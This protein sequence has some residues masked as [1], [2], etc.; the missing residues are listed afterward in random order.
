MEKY[1]IIYADP[2]WKYAK[3]N[4]PK[5]RFGIGMHRYKGMTFQEI[6]NL[7][8]FVKSL[9]AENCALFMWHVAPKLAQ[10]PIDVIFKNWGFRYVTKA[11]CWVK[12]DKKF[13]LRYLPGHYTGSNTEDCYLGIKGKMPRLNGG[14]NQVVLAPLTKHS[15]KPVI[16]RDRIVQLYGDLPRI[17]LFA[18][19]VVDGWDSW[20]D[21]IPG[22]F[23]AEATL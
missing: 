20:G 9:A 21:A 19:K 5:T 4:N 17:E 7:Q 23:Y 2:P 1:N 15:E 16:V 18:T 22:S 12:I 8:Q 6:L 3:R 10:Y 11:F 13:K 14:V